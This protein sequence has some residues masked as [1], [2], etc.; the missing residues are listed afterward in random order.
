[1]RS[2]RKHDKLH[3]AQEDSSVKPKIDINCDLGESFGRFK[4]GH[5]A[6]IMPF[7]TS[8][9]VACGFHAGDPI[10]MAQTVQVAKRNRVSVG[11]HP[12]FPD[13]AGFGR[14]PMELSAQEVRNIVI[15]QLGALQAFAES[16]GLSLQHVKPHGALYNAASENEAVGKAIMEG[17][18]A[19]DPRLVLFAS[20]KSKMATVAAEA[21]LRVAHEVFADRAYTPE[22]TLVSRKVAG[23]LI[24]EPK[25]VAKRAVRLVREKRVTAIN[26]GT[27]EFDEVHTICVH[28]DTLSAVE[29]AKSLNKA[30]LDAGLE[31]TPVGNFV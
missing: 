21:G 19:V 24:E 5:D 7:I 8:A 23:A 4:V 6:Q 22:G 2:L 28:G 26:G 3:Q 16:A 31:I 18:R 1:M 25:L 13:L 9:N 17:L 12:G 10:V 15:Y 20:A 27:V 29:I 14:R 11:A 30:L